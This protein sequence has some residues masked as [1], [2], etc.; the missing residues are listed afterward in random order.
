LPPVTSIPPV[1]AVL[2]LVGALLLARLRH[3]EPWWRLGVEGLVA[4]ALGGVPATYCFHLGRESG[5]PITILLLMYLGLVLG[6]LL[7]GIGPLLA[8]AVTRRRHYLA[9]G[10]GGALVGAYAGSNLAFGVLMG[11]YFCHGVA[12]YGLA[13]GLVGAFAVLGFQIGA[14]SLQAPGPPPRREPTTHPASKG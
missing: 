4:S 6:T 10:L 14:G 8:A 2:L 12:P 3:G 7:G 1:L 13:V 11:P 5:E 9:F